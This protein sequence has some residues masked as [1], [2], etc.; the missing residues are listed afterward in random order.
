MK[1]LKNRE[2]VAIMT[3]YVENLSFVNNPRV[4]P[5]ALLAG[6]SRA[7]LLNYLVFQRRHMIPLGRLPVEGRLCETRI[8][9]GNKNR[10]PSVRVGTW[11]RSRLPANVG[12]ALRFEGRRCPAV[13]TPARGS[14][15]RRAVERR[16]NRKRLVRAGKAALL[17]PFDPGRKRSREFGRPDLRRSRLLRDEAPRSTS[18]LANSC[19]LRAVLSGRDLVGTVLPQVPL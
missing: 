13:A 1:W 2:T 17:V 11:S 5:S 18:C 3:R 14:G 9:A 12:N 7:K 16:R 15:D 10:E 6:K 19:P 8:K 4:L